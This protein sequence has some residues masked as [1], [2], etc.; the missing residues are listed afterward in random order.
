MLSGVPVG[1]ED[2]ERENR[3]EADEVERA[4]RRR[5]PAVAR[6]AQLQDPIAKCLLTQYCIS[7]R[8]NHHIRTVDPVSVERGA[9]L[10]DSQVDRLLASCLGVDL[11][12]A[13]AS[14]PFEFAMRQAKLPFREGGFGAVPAL[15]SRY[16]AYYGS[17]VLTFPLVRELYQGVGVVGDQ[18]QRPVCLGPET[19]D[20][21]MEDRLLSLFGGELPK[22]FISPYTQ[23]ETWFD[24]FHVALGSVGE[25]E[26]PAD[27]CVDIPLPILHCVLA[28]RHVIQTAD[29]F[30]IT[31]STF[32]PFS[33]EAEPVLPALDF[34]TPQF[35]AQKIASDISKR[36]EFL[37]L[38][39]AARSA[40][41]H[42]VVARL[43]DCRAFGSGAFLRAIPG[44]RDRSGRFQ[45]QGDHWRIAAR[46]HVGLP[47]EGVAPADKCLVCSKRWDYR[48]SGSGRHSGG[49]PLGRS[50]IH[51]SVCSAGYFITRRHDAVAGVLAEMYES[52]G[53]T[54]AAD[55]KQALNTAKTATIGSVCALESGARVD[56]ILYGAGPGKE[57][58]A[59]DVSF[60]C[61]E[62]Y[63]HKWA[64][65][66]AVEEREKAKNLLYKDECAKAGMIFHPF[67]LGAHGGFGKEATAVWKLLNR[68]AAKVQGRDWR[69]SWT[70]MSFSSN[71]L[72]KLSI[73]VANQ[74]ATGALRRTTVCTRQRVLGGVGEST[75]GNYESATMGRSV[76]M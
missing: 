63:S 39:S 12:E 44:G 69:H 15:Q 37:S 59:I 47:P 50:A 75:D 40:G 71:W 55:H 42:D 17:C 73:A 6:V 58:V 31:T 36:A 64:F 57:D 2:V 22:R 76:A 51:P 34:S 24:A 29:K 67:V 18:P 65:K 13:R 48:P 27:L 54:A 26:L 43:D 3:F 62:A 20:A 21:D 4:V 35:K 8:Y 14:R 49:C 41:L 74:T 23:H 61:A 7:T 70:A 5:A 28:R 53:G 10:H 33:T 38:R 68:H 72:Q 46:C 60:V 25:G 11:D 32:K 16:S 56:V 1:P 52:L 9:R 19:I 66:A 30:K 45:M